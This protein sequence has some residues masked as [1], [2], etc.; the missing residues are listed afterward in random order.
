MCH[1]APGADR[2]SC[3]CPVLTQRVLSGSDAAYRATHAHCYVRVLFGTEQAASVVP[4]PGR[5][6]GV[7][8]T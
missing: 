6:W 3:D 1:A 8:G 7:T 4:G 5:S 2:A